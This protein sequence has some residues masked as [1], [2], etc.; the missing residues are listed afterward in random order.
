M[1]RIGDKRFGGQRCLSKS[2]SKSV[3]IHLLPSDRQI[4]RLNKLNS[5]DFGLSGLDLAI[6]A[7][8]GEQ[9][10]K[11]YTARPLTPPNN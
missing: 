6:Q 9:L 2:L 8:Q 4:R 11:S 10:P 7:E 5:A 1:E 3:T